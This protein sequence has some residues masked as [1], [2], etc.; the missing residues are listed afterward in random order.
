MIE[1]ICD[2]DGACFEDIFD[3]PPDSVALDRTS[4]D[5]LLVSSGGLVERWP[6]LHEL[7]PNAKGLLDV[8]PP[9]YNS[10]GDLA[11]MYLGQTF[12]PKMGCGRAWVFHQDGDWHIRNAKPMG[13]WI[14]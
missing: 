8:S 14:A 2:A 10:A 13:I 4:L 3:L 1:A 9:L 6:K 5:K 12:G 7:Y 11:L